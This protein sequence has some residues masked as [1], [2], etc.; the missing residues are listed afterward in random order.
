[1]PR[2]IC[3]ELQLILEIKESFLNR[4]ERARL[5]CFERDWDIRESIR[6]EFELPDLGPEKCNEYQ[7]DGMIQ[8]KNVWELRAALYNIQLR[9][10]QGVDLEIPRPSS[11]RMQKKNQP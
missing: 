7:S 6:R 3:F 5:D 9:A 10:S 1:M 2:R 8:K 11:A 4:K